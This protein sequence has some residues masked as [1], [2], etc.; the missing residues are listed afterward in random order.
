VWPSKYTEYSVKNTPWKQGKGFA[1]VKAKILRLDADR[2]AD[3]DR[4]AFGDFEVVT[5]K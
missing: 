4:M 3:G 2:L 1:P 5:K